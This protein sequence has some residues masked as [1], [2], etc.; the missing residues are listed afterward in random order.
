MKS[1]RVVADKD[2][3]SVM[4]ALNSLDP[5]QRSDIMELANI[6]NS[7]NYTDDEKHTAL[8]TIRFVLYPDSDFDGLD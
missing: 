7:N 1:N 5:E 4:C 3:K 8:V 2:I 6:I